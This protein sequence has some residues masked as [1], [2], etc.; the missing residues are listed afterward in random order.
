MIIYRFRLTS[1][2]QEDFFREIE[3]QPSQTFLD[4][5]DI[6]MSCSDLYHCDHAYF[7]ITDT[8]YKK[9]QEISFKFQQKKVQKYDSEMDEMV[10]EI[11]VPHLME[12]SKVKD[13]VEDPHQR[14]IYEFF[15][16]SKV[17]FFIELFR[18]IK[19][20]EMLS[21]PRCISR[22]GELP[23]KVMVPPV[24]EPDEEETLIPPSLIT[25]GITGLFA[26]I[27]E[28]D[29]ELEE[30]ESQLHEILEEEEGVEDQVREKGEMEEKSEEEPD[31]MESLEDYE[32]LEDLERKHRDFGNE[33]DDY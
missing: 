10:T 3:I 23:K 11:Y 1:E 26:D 30:I 20:E 24:P 5:H 12:K 25:P 31:Q 17:V 6:I 15:G 32:D 14:M 33:S 9:K 8:H 28:S 19:T 27:S 4:F 22:K 18:I 13:F 21:L 7:Y 29:S 16:P 2:D